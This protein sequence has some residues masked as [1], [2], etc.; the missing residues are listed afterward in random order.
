MNHRLEQVKLLELPEW[1]VWIKSVDQIPLPRDMGFTFIALF[2]L[3]VAATLYKVFCPTQIQESSE[4]RWV[5]EVKQNFLTYY[6]LS[7]S[8]FSIRWLTAICYGIGSPWIL[9]L[10]GR[11]MWMTMSTLLW[12]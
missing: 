10:L 11:R 5:H 6:S 4:I 2:V 7:Y 8:Q 9:F 1:M 12:T 3:A